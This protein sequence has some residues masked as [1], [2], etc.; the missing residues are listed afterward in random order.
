MWARKAVH[1]G[2]TMI[3]LRARREAI[4][5]AHDVAYPHVQLPPP[6]LPT[7]TGDAW[8][9]Q[10]VEYQAM[11]PLFVEEE[12]DLPAPAWFKWLFAGS[13]TFS[14]TIGYLLIKYLG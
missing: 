10:D 5:I 3:A 4:G 6:P 8:N 2:Q 11:A 7:M 14:V 9:Q 12:L 1:R 13:L